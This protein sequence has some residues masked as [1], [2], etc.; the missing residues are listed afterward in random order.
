MRGF[1]DAQRSL[2][3][4]GA[5]SGRSRAASN[6]VIDRVSRARSPPVIMKAAASRGTARAT[7]RRRLTARALADALGEA[8]GRLGARRG[9]A[10]PCRPSTRRGGEAPRPRCPAEGTSACQRLAPDR[11]RWAGGASLVG[12]WPQ[13]GHGRR[14]LAGMPQLGQRRGRS[15][16]G[17]T[18]VWRPVR[19]RSSHEGRTKEAASSVAPRSQGIAA[20]RGST[21]PRGAASTAVSRAF[22]SGESDSGYRNLAEY[23]RTARKRASGV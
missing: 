21:Q 14:R 4:E 12:P 18:L 9:L 1:A 10:R 13:V 15:P 16:T 20:M 17:D 22:L 23:D 2:L 3:S 11:S 7:V 8:A 6:A 19:V 5:F